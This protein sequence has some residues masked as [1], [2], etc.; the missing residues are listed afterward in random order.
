MSKTSA[1]TA[2]DKR[3]YV[4]LITSLVAWA[5][6]A[7]HIYTGIF[8]I[9][10]SVLQRSAHV[11]FAMLLVFLMHDRKGARRKGP[12]AWYDWLF[13][14]L[15]IISVGYVVLNADT[16]ASRY[17]YV[18]PLSNY[19]VFA[20]VIGTLLLLEA[21][22]RSMGLAL[23][24]IALAFLSYVYIGPH[25]PGILS[26]QGFTLMWT[27]DQLFYTTE[28]IWGIP[29]GVSATFIVMF[30]IFAAFLER[31]KGGDFFIDLA[32]GL[33]G[34]S[35]GGPA[36]ASIFASGF[37]GMLSGSAVANVVTTGTFTIPLMK[38]L[39]YSNRFAGAVESVAS[40]GGQFMPPIMG[41]AAFIVAEFMGEQ[42]IRVAAAAAI[43]A[44]LY[45]FGAFCM[46]HFEALRIDLKGLPADELP[47]VSK[48][49][50]FGV[51]FAIPV[52]VLVWLLVEGYSPMKAGLW[53]ILVTIFVSFVRKE[54]WMTPR[55][56][57]ESLDAGARG[58]VQVGIACATAGVI[59]GVLTLTGL[60]MRFTS[61]ILAISQGSLMITL[62]LTMVTS[63]IL[64]M[65]LPTVAAYII[66][67]TLTVPVLTQNYGVPPMAAHF[68]IFYFAIISAITPPVALAAYAASGIAGS[69]P[70]R[71]AVTACRLGLAAFIVP[72]M[73][74]YAPSL[75]LIGSVSEIIT[76]AIT[77]LVGVAA[78]AASMVGWL[79]FRAN[80]LERTFLLGAALSL[81]MPGLVT[82][83]AGLACLAI[84]F[85]LQYIR[86]PRIEQPA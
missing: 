68:F 75:L 74:V 46:V 36:K 43:P 54:T 67:V 8:G 27:V 12:L 45:Y 32:L 24:I 14:A 63:L 22:R 77:A 10:Q 60:G 38:K 2:Q 71:T 66:Q 44:I 26:H 35:R 80:L 42:Y 72:Y 61:I 34:K 69:D 23:P 81:I 73:F 9:F 57:L 7:F 16:I 49:L 83:G 50:V 40:S 85:L 20:G 1:K 3:S 25:L 4:E 53:A 29:A 65:G 28:G 5:M 13:L 21:A 31:S 86:R 37:M 17:S 62:L 76:S 48:T 84:A 15:T 58:A 55:R 18:T 51:Q 19:E 11:G 79:K 70:L 64:G 33:F 59:I 47:N 52:V 30:I 78:L 82:D 56:I 41:A 6:A 39:G